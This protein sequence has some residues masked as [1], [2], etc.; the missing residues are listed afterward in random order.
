MQSGGDLGITKR[1]IG[2]PFQKGIFLRKNYP[3]NGGSVCSFS[4][5]TAESH[6]KAVR[7]VPEKTT[8]FTPE[9]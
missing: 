6:T 5:G 2:K 7:F 8:P 3:Q 4:I 9:T 1:R